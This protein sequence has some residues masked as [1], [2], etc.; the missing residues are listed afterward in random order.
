MAFRLAVTEE[1]PSD[2]EFVTQHA[3]APATRR[4]IRL[5]H[6]W[7]PGRLRTLAL[8]DDDGD[9]LAAIGA[10]I[11]EDPG[12]RLRLNAHQVLSGGTAAI[13][14]ATEGPYPWEGVAHSEVFPSLLLMYPNYAG[15][16]VGPA[17]EDRAVLKEFVARITDWA[18]AQGLRSV[19]LL[20]LRASADPFIEELRAAGFDILKLTETCDLHVTW[21][22]LDGYFAH[23]PSK[24][25]V[26]ARRELRMLEERGIE[27]DAR[28]LAADEPEILDLRCQLAEKYDG[29]SDIERERRILNGLREHVAPEDLT[30]FTASKN[31]TMLGFGL[32]VRDGAEWTAAI[33]G[34]NYR[35]EESEFTYFANLY[36]QPAALA[37][38]YGIR[39]ISY[40]PGSWDAKRRRGC[41]LSPLYAAGLLLG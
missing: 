4:W 17:C 21:T 14:L 11:V 19:S 10:A 18:R 22:D 37:S 23:L 39:T 16:P 13:G 25:R 6:D 40:G 5:G 33:A 41:R 12:A 35:T 34:T 29:V 9:C 2:W 1:P 8:R 27:L 28:P 24:R 3:A 31:G 26:E 38:T 30:V 7:L 15:F 36:Y 20:F 32:M